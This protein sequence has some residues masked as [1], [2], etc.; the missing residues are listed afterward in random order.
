MNVAICDSIAE[1]LKVLFLLVYDRSMPTSAALDAVATKA[2]LKFFE[3]SVDKS[4]NTLRLL[5]CAISILCA[6]EMSGLCRASKLVHLNCVLARLV[7]S[8]HFLV[9]RS[10]FGGSAASVMAFGSASKSVVQFV[11]NQ[12]LEKDKIKARLRCTFLRQSPGS[13]GMV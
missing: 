13:F 4:V 6:R 5:A 8:I 11:S 7:S 3:V 10:S 9:F 12:V 2:K 1:T